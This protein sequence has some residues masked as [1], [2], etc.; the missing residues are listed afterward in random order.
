MGRCDLDK[1]DAAHVHGVPGDLLQRVVLPQKIR[2][3][4]SAV[5]DVAF[6]AEQAKNAAEAGVLGCDRPA[7]LDLQ[8][9]GVVWR[10]SG[11]EDS[12]KYFRFAPVVDRKPLMP[13]QYAVADSHS[14][15]RLA[16]GSA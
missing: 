4:L 12:V 13:C 11:G 6:A 7:V 2:V 16:L 5:G 15:Q 8:S 14:G 10:L 9:I 3:L 1:R